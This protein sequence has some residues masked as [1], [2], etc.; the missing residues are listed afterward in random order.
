MH[1]GSVSPHPC[2]HSLYSFLTVAL[3]MGVRWY[4]V[5]VLICIS[6]MIS[7]VEHHF[8]CLWDI[9]ISLWKHPL[10]IFESGCLSVVRLWVLCIFWYSS[11]IRYM[12]YEYFLPF[13]GLPFYSVA[14]I[15]WCTKI[16]N[17]H[18]A[19]FFCFLFCYLCCRCHCQAQCHKAFALCFLLRIL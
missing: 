7:D 8:M 17:F 2:C 10:P 1:R 14:S 13:C 19:K 5:V 12:I 4:L 9:C 16:F 6:L 15:L 3:L 11:L 18:K